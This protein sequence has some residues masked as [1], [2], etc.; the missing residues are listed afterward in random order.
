MPSDQEKYLGGGQFDMINTRVWFFETD[1]AEGH[2]EPRCSVDLD[3][4]S[5][6]VNGDVGE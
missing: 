3:P 4:D 2:V 5:I 6:S 1:L